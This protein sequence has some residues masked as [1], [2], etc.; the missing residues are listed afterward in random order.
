[1]SAGQV[2]FPEQ[3]L[4]SFKRSTDHIDTLRSTSTENFAEMAQRGNEKVLI[5]GGNGF[6]GYAVLSQ[7]LDSGFTV[8]AAFRRHSAAERVRTGPSMQKY[9][10]DG[11]LSFIVVPDLT[12]PG[13]LVP[14][15]AGC[16]GI[17]HVASP[18]PSPDADL[19]TPV[20]RSIQE[21]LRAAEENETVRRVVWTSP[22]MAMREFRRIWEG[23]SPT[24]TPL[25]SD[26]RVH[27]EDTFPDDAPLIQRFF[28]GR[29]AAMEAVHAHV[30]RSVSKSCGLRFD[31]TII[32]AG[33]IL[34]PDELVRSKE[35]AFGPTRSNAL[36]SFLFHDATANEGL[37]VDQNEANVPV[38]AETVHLADC[39]K[40]HVRALQLPH[41]NGVLRK[42]LLLSD[43]PYGP[44]LADAEKIV[45]DRLPAEAEAISFSGS[46][47][48]S[49]FLPHFGSTNT[50]NTNQERGTRSTT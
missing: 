23:Y 4:I 41:G 49:I 45:K 18:M 16:S 9:L 24:D 38:L 6:L 19:R 12:A 13:A 1:M 14:A 5:T 21:V 44:T 26:S 20:V 2:K 29:V 43:A 42:Y 27:M 46:M 35:E 47:G 15:A 48:A 39:A 10:K 28:S 34:G 7:A 36:L 22:T 37:G 50:L 3:I 32:I 30:D 33:T 8:L 31:V 17:V 11:R 25:T 40:G